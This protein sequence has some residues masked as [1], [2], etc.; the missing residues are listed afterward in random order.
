MGEMTDYYTNDCVPMEDD[1]QENDD[2]IMKEKEETEELNLDKEIGIKEDADE[3]DLVELLNML[4]LDGFV[5]FVSTPIKSGQF[6]YGK[7]AV[8]ISVNNESLELL[9][10]T[11]EKRLK[12]ALRLCDFIN[13]RQIK[14][15]ALPEKKATVQIQGKKVNF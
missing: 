1:F 10:D 9:G 13:K 12:V 3:D 15:K 5:A 8:G 6:L 14:G 2:D 4:K 11:N 7:V